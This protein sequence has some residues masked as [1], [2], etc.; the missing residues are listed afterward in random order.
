MSRPSSAACPPGRRDQK[1]KGR[2]D[3]RGQR[4]RRPGGREPRP[5]DLDTV[6]RVIGQMRGERRSKQ[7]QQAIADS[8]FRHD[9]G[10]PDQEGGGADDSDDDAE[11]E[12]WA[13]RRRYAAEPLDGP[14]NAHRLAGRNRQRE[15]TR[16][17]PQKLRAAR[18]ACRPARERGEDDAR[19]FDK[20]EPEQD[21]PHANTEYRQ[22]SG[23]R[24][25][26]EARR[27]AGVEAGEPKARPQ[28][29]DRQPAQC[30]GPAPRVANQRA[31]RSA[32]VGH[33]ARFLAVTLR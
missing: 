14:R 7:Q 33:S 1:R 11:A 6:G 5:D 2:N 22:V 28:P 26:P 32:Q 12:H 20:R 9:P 29:I 4:Q 19:H 24:G 8:P 21:R 25:K 15:D 3:Q 31:C 17:S 13:G 10:E 23:Q 30:D 16:R 18:A 27:G